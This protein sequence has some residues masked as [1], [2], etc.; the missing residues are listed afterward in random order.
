MDEEWSFRTGK[1]DSMA[2]GCTVVAIAGNAIAQ[3]MDIPTIHDGTQIVLAIQPEH[4]PAQRVFTAAGMV[5]LN[6]ANDAGVGVVVNNLSQSPSAAAGLPVAFVTRGILDHTTVDAAAK[7][8]ESVP[9]AVGQHYLIG[10]PIGLVSIEGAANGTF[11]VPVTD[12]YVHTNHPLANV[13]TRPETTEIERA[14]NTHARFDR[15]TQLATS[16]RDQDDLQRILEDREAP[17]SCERKTGFMTFGGIS[18][19]FTVP[20]TMR[21]TAGPP[22]ESTWVDVGWE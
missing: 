13:Q 8:V 14:S 19:G 7:W 20:P 2:P 12:H 6:G 11:R 21:V 10:G 22:H 16:A 18:I 3:T 1:L 5:G 9:H 17:I 4:G 15:A